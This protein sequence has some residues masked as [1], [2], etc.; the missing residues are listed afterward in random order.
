MKN[1]K[2]P[3]RDTIK[4]LAGSFAHFKCNA[5]AEETPTVWLASNTWL[6]SLRLFRLQRHCKEG[7]W[8][9]TEVHLNEIYHSL[10]SEH[11]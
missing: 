9:Q 8:Y 7:Y 2:L 11:K 3:N 10:Y 6:Q 1:V 5:S 4:W